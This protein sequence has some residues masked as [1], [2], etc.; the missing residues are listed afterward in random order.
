MLRRCVGEREAELAVGWGKRKVGSCSLRNR[1]KVSAESGVMGS[2]PPLQL[3]DL[4]E[5]CRSSREL[6]WSRS[7]LSAES[8]VATSPT[9]LLF[10]SRK[11]GADGGHF[12]KL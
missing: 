10:S 3:V 4:S 2:T 5:P 9:W 8:L 6:S 12:Y 1:E 7:Q 11:E